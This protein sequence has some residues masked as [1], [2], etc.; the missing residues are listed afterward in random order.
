MTKNKVVIVGAGISG[1]TVA[2]E[3]IE[4]GFE[5]DVYEKNSVAGGMARSVRTD[6]GIPSEHSWRGYAPFYYNTFEI[7]SR[8]PI[9]K[10]LNDYYEN[11]KRDIITFKG[12]KYDITEFIPK[13][14]GGT[15]IKKALESGEQPLEKVWKENNV[16]WHMKNPYVMRTLE[17]YKINSSKP[18]DVLDNLAKAGID[19]KLLTN[20]REGDTKIA[21]IDYPY[22]AYLFIKYSIVHKRDN[23]KVRLID[24]VWPLQETSKQ[25][26]LDYLS[27]PGW[28]FDKT[29]ISTNH[30]FKF[31]Y[32][33]L[34]AGNY[35][36]QVMNQPTSEAWI[37]PWVDYLKY[38][39][40]RFHFNST[41][42]SSVKAD[43][44]VLAIP[45]KIDHPNDQI[46]FRLGFSKKISFPNRSIAFIL[47][48]SEYNIT[49]YAQ[50]E[51]WSKD[52]DIGPVASLWS[53]TIINGK[54]A[55]KLKPKELL[56]E[57][58]RQILQSKY[59]KNIISEDDIVYEE[60][61][62]DWY[63]NPRLKRL[64]SK[65][66][67]WVNRVNEVRLENKT[68]YPNI[69]LAG[70][71]TKTT[72]D[73]WSMESAVESGKMAS[74]LI[75]E[76]YGLKKCLLM[77]HTIKLGTFDDPF[78]TAGLPHILDCFFITIILLVL[79]VYVYK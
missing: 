78:Y 46:S 47:L 14:P 22:L 50:D 61:F 25:Y 20:K 43:E 32:Q 9:Q 44:Y 10:K 36:W 1:L 40:V 79:F 49:F 27:G 13:H 8:I 37:D 74:N 67:K 77:S 3:L 15:I 42:T 69:W 62:E 23:N 18:P 30:Y 11:P 52:V 39:G 12:E 73:I 48:D 57:I 71:H 56:K 38:K 65:N 76:K 41:L 60:L 4:K 6:S 68:E 55:V 72:I 28:G 35:S 59:I 2:H 31:L 33:Q 51:H 53:G 19:F 70:A 17:K 63:W 64:V 45:P 66:P 75:L 24:V 5:V 58:K 54:N 21:Y 7:M 16:A 26:L 34:Y 29:T